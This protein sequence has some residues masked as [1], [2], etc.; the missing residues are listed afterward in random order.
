M[1]EQAEGDESPTLKDDLT[2]KLKQAVENRVPELWWIDIS[3]K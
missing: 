1:L 2:N 3:L